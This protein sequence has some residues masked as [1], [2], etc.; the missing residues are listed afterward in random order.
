MDFDK[1]KA[2]FPARDIEWRVSRAGK[3]AKGVWAK[4][5]A[6]VTNRAI[7]ER[8]DEVCGPQN[9]RN[10]YERAPEGGVLCGISIRIGDEWVTK[11]DGAGNTDIEAV[12]G[13]LS[14]AM[15]RAAVQWGIGRYLYS[16]EEGWANVHDSGSHY[17]AESKKAPAF[18]WD[19]PEL[20]AWAL[21]EGDTSTPKPVAA[22]PP[23]S[24]TDAKPAATKPDY[25]QYLELGINDISP[26]KYPHALRGE[27]DWL[28]AHGREQAADEFSE[29]ARQKKDEGAANADYLETLQEARKTRMT[30][31]DIDGREKYKD[32][33]PAHEDTERPEEP[34][35]T[36]ES[37]GET[38]EEIVF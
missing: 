12:K 38:Q 29:V 28:R 19:P 16:L 33:E 24:E 27:I 8:L 4:V 11:W 34:A 18:R 5:L 22:A 13:G 9:W 31:E 26:S 7:M 21:P 23:D 1:L 14:G 17:Q 35:A 30:A 2:P 10:A 36:S 20:P 32:K 37:T 3:N 15:K 6:Y 25:S